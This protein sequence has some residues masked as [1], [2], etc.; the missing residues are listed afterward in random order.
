MNDDDWER[1]TVRKD[2]LQ[3]GLDW[4]HRATIYPTAAV[5][6]WLSRHHEA[7]LRKAV[8]LAD[9]WRR[10]GFTRDK[11]HE[12]CTAF[13]FPMTSPFEGRDKGGGDASIWEGLEF[14]VKYEGYL[15]RERELV[16]RFQ[17]G[18][19]LQIPPS[20]IYENI[21]GLSHE[22]T[23]RLVQIKPRTLGQAA[24]IPGVTPAAVSILMVWLRRYSHAA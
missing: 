20:F 21:P 19:A 16:E 24:R 15:A 22:I 18:E 2:S 5:N 23:E 13:P 7:P 6:E 8:A 11:L 4:A 14:A 17:K 3:N 9:L 1:F 10:P 12:F